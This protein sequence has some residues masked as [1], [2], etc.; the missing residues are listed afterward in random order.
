MRERKWL[1]RRRDKKSQI[2]IANE[3]GITQ[4]AY[5]AIEN[6]I[7]NPSVAIAK[8]IA[9]ILDFDWTKFFDDDENLK[10]TG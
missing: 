6:G 4:Q 5:S 8:K 9:A 2:N 10:E 3:V 7:R 1:I